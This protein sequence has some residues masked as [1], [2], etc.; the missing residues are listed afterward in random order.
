MRIVLASERD[1]SP[2]ARTRTAL[3]VALACLAC[4]TSPATGPTPPPP[5]PRVECPGAGLCAE[6]ERC[7]T[8]ELL[9]G[10]GATLLTAGACPRD[11]LAGE[12]THAP[13]QICC[14]RAV[15]TLMT[16]AACVAVPPDCDDC[17]CAPA[18]VCG[19]PVQVCASMPDDFIRCDIPASA[20]S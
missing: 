5:R 19:S 6:G 11:T 3:L 18:D 1:C 20:R 12:C 17:S 9:V 7:R 16:D 15:G 2:R 10:V 13:G 8:R 4:R 14:A